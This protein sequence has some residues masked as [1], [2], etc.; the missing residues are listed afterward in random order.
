MED[1]YNKYVEGFKS[2]EYKAWG[3][4]KNESGRKKVLQTLQNNIK[5]NCRPEKGYKP[6]N[7][8][9]RKIDGHKNYGHRVIIIQ[10]LNS[11]PSLIQGIDCVR[12]NTW[13]VQIKLENKLK[14]N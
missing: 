5:D 14:K 13:K 10:I 2:K 8:I 11:M 7:K 12:Y 6:C 9:K 4:P 1:H 3:Y